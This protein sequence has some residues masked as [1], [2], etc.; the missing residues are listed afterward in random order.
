MM[1]HLATLIVSSLLGIT[2]CAVEP[3][4]EESTDPASTSLATAQD[5][6][7]SLSATNRCQEDLLTIADVPG[8]NGWAGACG[9]LTPAAVEFLNQ[10]FAYLVFTT[11]CGHA[12]CD[13]FVGVTLADP[14]VAGLTKFAFCFFG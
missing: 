4:P 11:G 1:K 8:R 9:Y 10:E 5:P 14:C 3:V 6:L 12:G 2:A 7:S 13:P